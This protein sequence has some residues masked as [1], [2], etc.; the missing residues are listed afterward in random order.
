MTFSGKLLFGISK[1]FRKRIIYN[2]S[3]AT[4]GL[5]SVWNSYT[6]NKYSHTQ[7]REHETYGRRSNG[8]KSN[9]NL[10]FIIAA[11]AMFF[12]LF[13]PEKT[14]EE[15]IPDLITTIK[16]SILMIQRGEFK[17]A[18]QMLHVALRQAQSLQNYD[19]VTYIYDVM[20]N[21]AFDVGDYQKAESLFV[22]VMQRLISSGTP[23]DDMKIIHISLKMAK[24]YE[25]RGD[26]DKA[27][28]GYKFCLE[29]LQEKVDKGVEN[30]DVIM[31]WGMA[32]DWYAR[33]LLSQLK[34]GEA[35][36][37]FLKAYQVCVKINGQEHEQTVVLLND[38]GSIS[39]LKG[40]NEGA[41]D[42][43]TQATEIG[44]KLPDMEELATIHVNL[45]N[46]FIKRGMFD[47]AKKSCQEGWN[48][49]KRRNNQESLVEAND[50]LEEINKLLAS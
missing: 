34:H 22:T 12:G 46:V 43:F 17:K 24:L 2:G 13:E 4:K 41:V 50:C 29:H 35:F 47:A 36:K 31:L 5:G 42:Y 37:Y 39:F 9:P 10:K 19:A 20:A 1:L 25:Q 7:I 40:D 21:L 26:A 28:D 45:G 49:S 15:Q 38:L 48:L 18:E 23:K 44:K 8:E 30:E 6:G 14:N 32:M 27:E 16:R 11:N 33:M 3:D